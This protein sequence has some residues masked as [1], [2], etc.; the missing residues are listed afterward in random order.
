MPVRITCV[1]QLIEQHKYEVRT[2]TCLIRLLP[3]TEV[4]AHINRVRCASK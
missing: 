2:N 3:Q 4:K 1:N